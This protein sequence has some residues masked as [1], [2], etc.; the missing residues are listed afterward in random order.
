MKVT[1]KYNLPEVF[2][3]AVKNDD[4]SPGDSDITVTQ[5]KDP[6]RKIALQK[7]YAD[8]LEED[9]SGRGYSLLGQA[10]HVILERA[11]EPDAIVEKRFYMDVRGWKI[12]GQIDYYR[13]G[14]LDDFKVT[15]GYVVK[16]H[17]SG[18][19]NDWDCQLNVNALLMAE[20]GIEV[21]KLGVLA[22]LRDWSKLE[23]MRDAK[24]A[25]DHNTSPNYPQSQVAV[26]D[27]PMWGEE[28][29][30]K[31]L[32]G[33]VEAHQSAQAGSE[34]KLPLCTDEERW[35]KADSFAVMKEGRKSALRVLRWQDEAERWARDNGHATEA[36]SYENTQENMP[37]DIILKNG[38]SID[39]RKGEAIRCQQYCVARDVCSQFKE[40]Q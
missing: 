26:V 16:G 5:L 27:I 6:P 20:N 40:E 10:V 30:L 33:R 13:N 22:L 11:A 14:R 12:G 39:H 4:Y 15:S 17:R 29:T 24:W 34:E 28:K 31:W 25:N 18:E 38:I 3:R 9:C 35:K 19:K 8:Q 7:L 37:A 21:N 32:E 1:N 23:A 36:N 2:Y